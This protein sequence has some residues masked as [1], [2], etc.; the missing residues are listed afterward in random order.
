MRHLPRVRHVSLCGFFLVLHGCESFRNQ[1]AV[2]DDAFVDVNIDPD[3]VALPKE[4]EKVVEEVP[5]AKIN[6]LVV[7]SQTPTP[8]EE[9]EA[10]KAPVEVATVNEA[11]KTV[12]NKI[13]GKGTQVK[14]IK[15]EQINIRSKPNRYSKI[16][17]LLHFGDE[18]HV[19]EVNADWAK[20]DDGRYIRTRWLVKS[21]PGKSSKAD[22]AE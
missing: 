4:S 2:S 1:N 18:V 6:P 22:A 21:A 9:V 13:E 19:E 5:Q 16:L 11:P 12:K 3:A 7:V 8:V 17:G 10:K 20:L 15:A 14:F